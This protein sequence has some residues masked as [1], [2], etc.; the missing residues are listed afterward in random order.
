M[1]TPLAYR[2]LVYIVNYNGALMVYD[3]KTGERKYQQRLADGSTAFTASP[4]AADG[5]V[6][7]ASEDGHI[8]VLKAGPTY[9]LL[10][11]NEMAES[12][13]AT[14]ALSEGMMFWRTQGQVDCDQVTRQSLV[15]GR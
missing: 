9:E 12:T 15:A 1:A 10:S 7:F 4:V 11:T 5:K 6:Y 8:F 13:L 3:A 14:P 2:G